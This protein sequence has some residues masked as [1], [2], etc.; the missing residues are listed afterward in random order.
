M[1]VPTHAQWEPQDRTER[2]RKNIC[3]NHGPKFSK[4]NEN[5]IYIQEAQQTVSRIN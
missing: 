5:N 3:R 1:R 4:Y 2:G